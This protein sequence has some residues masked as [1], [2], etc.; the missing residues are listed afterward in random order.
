MSKRKNSE[1]VPVE[2]PAEVFRRCYA[3]KVDELPNNTTLVS[4][5]PNRA[6][7]DNFKDIKCVKVYSKK[8]LGL[9]I[10]LVSGDEAKWK[11]VSEVSIIKIGYNDFKLTP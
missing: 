10:F 7:P 3:Y 8:S 9:E 11:K 1:K 2:T 6:V 5:N 4:V